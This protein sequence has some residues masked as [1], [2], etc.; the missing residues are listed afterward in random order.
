MKEFRLR[1]PDV[2]ILGLTATANPKMIEDIKRHLGTFEIIVFKSSFNRKNLF[3][4]VKTKGEN[5]HVFISNIINQRF[6]GMC[7][8]VYCMTIKDV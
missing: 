6:R 2:P 5:S 4:S 3:F 1:F 7:G 8:I